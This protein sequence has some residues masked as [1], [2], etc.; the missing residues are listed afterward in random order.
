VWWWDT[1]T[2]HLRGRVPDAPPSVK[3]LAISPDGRTLAAGRRLVW[4]PEA[5]GP[6]SK[7]PMARRDAMTTVSYALN[8][9]VLAV[10]GADKTLRLLDAHTGAEVRRFKGH[11]DAVLALAFAPDGKT[12]A[13]GGAD[14]AVRLWSLRDGEELR[15][16]ETP[17]KAIDVAFVEQGRQLVAAVGSSILLW[18]V[19]TGEKLR[20][21]EGH[22]APIV[23]LAVAES[24][25]A[26]ASASRDGTVKLWDAESGEQ[27]SELQAPSGSVTRVA[28][29]QDG[30]TLALGRDDGQLLL[31]ARGT[32]G[33]WFAAHGGS[34]RALA[35][36]PDG[37][38]LLSAGDDQS[39]KLW[40]LT[41][42][43]EAK[44][45]LALGGHAQPVD[46]LAF[47]PDGATFASA[48]E[49]PSLR[50]W[51]RAAL[52]SFFAASPRAL[53]IE[54]QQAMALNPTPALDPAA[55]TS[56]P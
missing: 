5:F 41:G 35:F 55:R 1:A 4:L 9:E 39:L 26:L 50:L 15:T 43:T 36:S 23:S 47:S 49:D 28:F 16:I 24:T 54:A 7:T 38:L 6:E 33:T 34:V 13:S 30:Q 3:S 2:R 29:S 8:G 37:K 45:L 52:E 11:A 20:E 17:G 27:S 51:S 14:K 18:D 42:D 46:S 12:L 25:H 10:A 56:V 53:L 21:L 40:R 22:T 48:G 19:A 32:N 44:E 31:R